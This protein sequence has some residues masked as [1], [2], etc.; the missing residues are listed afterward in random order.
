MPGTNI[1]VA[2]GV[3]ASGSAGT[4]LGRDVSPT[5]W[6]ETDSRNTPIVSLGGGKLFVEGTDEV[7]D[8]PPVI[9][10]EKAS[11]YKF[12]LI[13]K[14]ALDR[15]WTGGA[16]NASTSEETI[17]FVSTVGMQVGMVLRKKNADSPEIIHVITVTSTTSIEAKRNIGGTAYEIAGADEWVCVSWCQ[18]DG[19][20][21]RATRSITADPRTR[22]VQI[23]KNTFSITHVLDAS[24]EVVNT[25][26][27]SEE[28]KLAAREH[29]L[30]KEGAWWFNPGADS[31]TDA[32]GT[33]CWLA[34]GIIAE[35]TAYTPPGGSAGDNVIDCGGSLT[36]T[37]LFGSFAEQIFDKGAS[38]KMAFLDA[39][40]ISKIMS[41]PIGKLQ[42]QPST[43]KTP[44]G[45]AVS[46]LV[47]MHGILQIVHSGV[48]SKF[49]TAA[50][51]GYGLIIEPN[52]LKTKV[53]EGYDSRYE[54]NI[55][56]PGASKKEAQFYSICGLRFANLGHHFI[57]KNIG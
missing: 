57:T 55:Q 36:E 19:G 1:V 56:T 22:Y 33:T 32:D 9:G 47:S 15:D 13:E 49:M 30:D 29:N 16:A 12:D 21:K 28:M 17:A 51:A 25:N 44:Y 7:K 42:V 48:A 41:F 50:E 10:K 27:W 2:K 39:H 54:D 11:E 20:D 4:E 3:E 23:F 24:E 5:I 37:K 45:L 52:K 38:E 14:D 40:F 8:I 35:I 26:A 46:E 31:T 43:K 34:R 18:K 6:H 53:M